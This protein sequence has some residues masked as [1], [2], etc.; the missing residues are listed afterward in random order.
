ML[1]APRWLWDAKRASARFGRATPAAWVE[2]SVSGGVGPPFL[3]GRGL[4]PKDGAGRVE[5]RG[6][7]EA[8][9]EI[10]GGGGCWSAPGGWTAGSLGMSSAGVAADAGDEQGPGVGSPTSVVLSLI[11]I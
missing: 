6:P 4:G 10:S 3:H 2:R 11:H 8:E 5:K 7:R 1:R 9:R